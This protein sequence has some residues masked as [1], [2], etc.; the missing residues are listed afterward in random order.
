MNLE[1]I[2]RNLYEASRTANL[3]ATDHENLCVMYQQGMKLLDN[4]GKEVEESN[5]DTSK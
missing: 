2:L 4:L 5:H 3:S 1:T